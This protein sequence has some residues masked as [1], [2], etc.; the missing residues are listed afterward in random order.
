[1]KLIEE[2]YKL[3]DQIKRQED[4]ETR[5][6][7]D[8]RDS[9]RGHS[10]SLERGRS[11]KKKAKRDSTGE[12]ERVARATAVSGRSVIASSSMCKLHIPS[13]RRQDGDTLRRRRGTDR[14][15]S[16]RHSFRS[17]LGGI[18]RAGHH[19]YE[20]A[21]AES[22]ADEGGVALRGTD[23]NG[24]VHRALAFG[25]K[26]ARQHRA[27]GAWQTVDPEGFASWKGLVFGV[28]GE[29]LQEAWGNDSGARAMGRTFGLRPD[30]AKARGGLPSRVGCKSGT[31][32]VGRCSSRVGGGARRG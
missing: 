25:A 14:S 22:L 10:R 12:E 8:S 11:P 28:L 3:R 20:T 29:A 24:S 27:R 9:S 6:R 5:G 18:H 26:V 1:M 31:P 17:Q 19:S 21:S 7:R 30:Q 16:H 15:R 4:K 23:A 2:N 13:R 32:A